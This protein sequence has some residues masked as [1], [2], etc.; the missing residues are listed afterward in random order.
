MPEDVMA[1]NPE[2]DV[3]SDTS[4]GV[5]GE[6][7]TSVADVQTDTTTESMDATQP[8]ETEQTDT[9][10][11][12]TAQPVPE[13]V[14]SGALPNEFRSLFKHQDP[15]IAQLAPKIQGLWDKVQ[16]YSSYGSVADMKQFR[17]AFP[18]GLQDAINASQRAM[19]LDEVDNAYFSR[20]PEQHN[21]LAR[22]WATNDPEAFAMLAETS[23]NTLAAMNPQAYQPI[24]LKVLEGTLQNL[25]RQANQMGN[26]Q[27]AQRL[28]E[29][30]K[31]VFGRGINEQPRVDPREAQYKAREEAINQRE[32]QAINRATSQFTNDTNIHVAQAVQSIIQTNLQTAL[33]KYR[34]S[35]GARQRITQ[36]IYDDINQK[37]IADK[38]LQ[39]RLQSI[40]QAGRKTGF[41]D[42]HRQQW[43][44]AIYNRAR[45]L[46]TGSSTPIVN[47]WTQDILSASKAKI[48]KIT[49]AAS[50]KDIG[51]GGAPNY[52]MNPLTA[53]Q[54]DKMS[55]A[56][57]L[58]YQGPISPDARAKLRE[59]KFKR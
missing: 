55:N 3:S 50:R 49:S 56:E 45:N 29:L 6:T 37:L 31:D 4:L 54:I 26:Q 14:T 2:T 27:A 5:G 23:L 7:D 58:A 10:Q 16:A 18:G 51:S 57:L 43:S 25:Y 35:D 59:N 52:G 30:M 36:E 15:A 9:T 20:D 44:E 8:V 42:Q 12:T 11:D 41:T 34:V 17:E 39:T 1:S 32:M 46:L 21:Q 22:D 24:G 33:A 19:E 53:E 40:A 47:R 48:D 13:T 38:G 28:D